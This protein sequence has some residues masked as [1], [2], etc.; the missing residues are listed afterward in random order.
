MTPSAEMEITGEDTYGA[1]YLKP[2][3]NE[4]K[5]SELVN[6]ILKFSQEFRKHTILFLNR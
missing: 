4:Q 3:C 5:K 1:G 2:A 6:E